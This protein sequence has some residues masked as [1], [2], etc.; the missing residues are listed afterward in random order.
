MGRRIAFLR[1]HRLVWALSLSGLLHVFLVFFYFRWGEEALF[2][3]PG[4]KTE[5]MER[6]IIFE[7]IETS[8][9]SLRRV[10]PREACLL[11]DKNAMARDLEEKD[12]ADAGLP[13]SDGFL[14]AKTVPRMA[15]RDFEGNRTQRIE[16]AEKKSLERGEGFTPRIQRWGKAFMFSRE[17]LLDREEE[18]PSAATHKPA[19]KQKEFDAND[20]GGISFN[21]YAWDF[22]PYFLYLKRLNINLDRY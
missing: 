17:L 4:R 10:P 19:Y 5:K 7:I 18:P 2:R 1:E 8:E 3:M 11:S 22:A 15:V 20:F 6:T 14:E 9:E 21:T 12:L 13:Y 16:G